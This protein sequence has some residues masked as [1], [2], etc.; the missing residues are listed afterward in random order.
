MGQI[1]DSMTPVGERLGS[2]RLYEQNIPTLPGSFGGSLFA[3]PQPPDAPPDDAPPESKQ[4][5]A[6][7]KRERRDKRVKR[8]KPP[9]APTQ[10]SPT[11]SKLA[12]VNWR[13]FVSSCLEVAGIAAITAGCALI[14]P[15]VG[16][17][18]GGILLVVLGVATGLQVTK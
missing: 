1:A 5:A 11:L 12:D 7:A 4:P 8:A 2:E 15:I 17:I 13:G 14:A 9:P 6:R 10:K 16:F 3:V 18:V